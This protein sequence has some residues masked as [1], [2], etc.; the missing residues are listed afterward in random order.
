MTQG[1][2]TS[3]GIAPESITHRRVLSVAVPI[4]L[5]NITIPVLGAVDTGVVGQ[6]GEAAPIGA[7]GIGAIIIAAL[8]WFFGF[9]RMGTSGLAA[10]ARGAGDV[11][12]T[13][14]ILTRGLLAGVAGGVLFLVL[15][16]PLFS[17]AFW[18][19]PGSDEVEGLA[20]EYLSIRAWGAP[21]AIALMAINGWLIAMERTRAV[22]LLQLWMNGLNIVL[23]LWF[24]LSL[25]LGVSGVA[26]ATIIAEWSGLA[27]GLFLCAPAFAGEQWRDWTR[28]FNGARLRQMAVVN[29]DI[30]VR[31]VALNAMFLMFLFQSAGF[32]DVTLAANQILIQFLEITAYGLDGFAFAAEALVGQA[33]GAGTLRSLR[34]S[35]ILTSLWG[36]GVVAVM[37]LGFWVAGPWIIDVM[38]TATDVREEANN[39]L[40]WVVFSPVVGMASW[41]LDGIFI[42]AM[43]TRDMR[44]AAIESLVVYV[45][46]WW[47]LSQAFGNHGLWLALY[48]SFV[49]RGLTLWLRYPALE[50]QAELVN[51]PN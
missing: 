5:S 46:A 51:G 44:R 41:M 48:V 40:L 43:R 29:F 21:A 2:G 36:G 42:G 33:M 32:G 9:L 49:A 7:V 37:A 1:L 13:G 38:T 20:R 11:A 10:Q 19:S 39:Y 25:G 3:T 22:L 27:L 28:V 45:V 23:D 47:F 35:A 26:T 30:M 6:M 15:Q 12:E 8:Y 18:L 16:M 34:R 24:V 4:V 14:A 50:R 17:L 31:S